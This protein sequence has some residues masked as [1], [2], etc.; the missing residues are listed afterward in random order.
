MQI[1]HE[2]DRFVRKVN[3]FIT[4]ASALLVGTFR[5]ISLLASRRSP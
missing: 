1:L 2:V 4:G 3:A 5:R